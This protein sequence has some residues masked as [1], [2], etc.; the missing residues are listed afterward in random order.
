METQDASKEVE[1]SS[2]LTA[3]TRNLKLAQEK[4]KQIDKALELSVQTAK[5]KLALAEDD[6]KTL[7]ARAREET[8]AKTAD[9]QKMVSTKAAAAN[10]DKGLVEPMADLQKAEVEAKKDDAALSKQTAALGEANKE[11]QRISDKELASLDSEHRLMSDAK[12]KQQDVRDADKI[13]R[14]AKQKEEE[15]IKDEGVAAAKAANA[16]KLE[17]AKEDIVGKRGAIVQRGEQRVAKAKE[18]MRE[19]KMEAIEAGFAAARTAAADG[20]STTDESNLP[21]AKAEQLVGAV[22][23]KAQK[24]LSDVELRREK[25]EIVEKEEMQVKKQDGIGAAK[26]KQEALS[27]SKEFRQQEA[28][29]AQLLQSEQRLVAEQTAA[30]AKADQFEQGIRSAEMKAQHAQSV[31]KADMS[32]IKTKTGR[33]EKDKAAERQ[34]KS[35]VMDDLSGNNQDK[36]KVQHLQTAL[37]H[38]RKQAAAAREAA[39]A[40]YLS[41]TDSGHKDEVIRTLAEAKFNVHRTERMIQKAQAATASRNAQNVQLKMAAAQTASALSRDKEEIASLQA[42][43]DAETS[44]LKGA[45]AAQAQ[46]TEDGSASIAAATQSKVQL[47]QEQTKLQQQESAVNQARQQKAATDSAAGDASDKLAADQKQESQQTKRIDDLKMKRSADQMALNAALDKKRALGVSFTQEADAEEALQAEVAALKRASKRENAMQQAF[48]GTEGV[49][50]NAKAQV[51][52]DQS[53]VSRAYTAKSK[54]S[55]TANNEEQQL[56]QKQERTKRIEKRL[57]E[58]QKQVK[59]LREQESKDIMAGQKALAT[60]VSQKARVAQSKGAARKATRESEQAA[61]TAALAGPKLAKTTVEAE[62]AGRI[63]N[64]D[65][66]ALDWSRHVAKAE[67][68]LALRTTKLA[69]GE[70]ETATNRSQAAEK[71]MG[72]DESIREQLKANSAEAKKLLDATEFTSDSTDSSDVIKRQLNRQSAETKA[73]NVAEQEQAKKTAESQSNFAKFDAQSEMAIT[74]ATQAAQGYGSADTSARVALEKLKV[75]LPEDQANQADEAERKTRSDLELQ[76]PSE[77]AKASNWDKQNTNEL[78]MAARNAAGPV[79]TLG[80]SVDEQDELNDDISLTLGQ[81]L[82][83]AQLALDSGE[84]ADA[85]SAYF[86]IPV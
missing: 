49:D 29:A 35:A 8:A 56:Q 18:Q 42:S 22:V 64:H 86:A 75:L 66:V 81:S 59:R 83:K 38:A 7:A 70:F 68:A 54:L 26:A 60:E 52:L 6:A 10:A 57:G 1:S 44:N 40:L 58:S 43:R 69:Q 76:V 4:Q 24:D 61:H 20:P 27:A 62:H 37:A 15:A 11:K 33:L 23:A 16:A 34:A 3:A 13:I 47:Q 30:A 46:A 53:F 14:M 19:A 82:H 2:E 28:S 17:Q 45:Q 21:N 5:D 85:I 77:V 39:E 25:D 72:N 9:E 67:T 51:A 79:A 41:G 32:Y 50:K 63:V 84:K 31:L 71:S 48:E 80:E 74:A 73:A 36:M 65:Q 78:S 12:R 55:R